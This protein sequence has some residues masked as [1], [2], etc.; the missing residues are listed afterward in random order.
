[1]ETSRILCEFMF[2]ISGGPEPCVVSLERFLTGSQEVFG[3]T[4]FPKVDTG[5]CWR[6]NKDYK[7]NLKGKILWVPTHSTDNLAFSNAGDL[8]NTLSHPQLWP[9]FGTNQIITVLPLVSFWSSAPS[10]SSSDWW[11]CQLRWGRPHRWG[12]AIQNPIP[13]SKY[14]GLKLIVQV[15][16]VQLHPAKRAHSPPY[17]YINLKWRRRWAEQ[18][19]N[20]KKNLHSST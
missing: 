2:H 5:D 20:G 12:Q 17:L 7:G 6:T 9:G 16:Q 11:L 4:P 1:M 14:Y 10:G 8:G 18:P 3:L 19:W 15:G 13:L